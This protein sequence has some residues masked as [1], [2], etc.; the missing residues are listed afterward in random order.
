MIVTWIGYKKKFLKACV[1][2]MFFSASVWL[3]Y[4]IYRYF[5][6]PEKIGPISIH[7]GAVD[8]K[9]RYIEQNEWFKGEAI[10]EKA[11]P[12]PPAS[13]LIFRLLIG[14]FSQSSAVLVWGLT[15]L[16]A[17]GWLVF[18]TIKEAQPKARLETIFVAMI[19]LSMYASGACIGN[20]QLILHIVPSLITALLLLDRETQ[21]WQT[22]LAGIVLM[23]FSLIKPTVAAPFFWIVLFRKKG[24]L[25][26]FLVVL[27][28]GGLTQIAA[29]FQPETSFELMRQWALRGIQSSSYDAT[30]WSHNNLHS[31]STALGIEKWN[32]MLSIIMMAALGAWVYIHRSMD[33][34]ALIGVCAVVSRFWTYHGW[35]DDLLIL[36]PM[37]TLFRMT[38][39]ESASDTQRLSAG[40]F[41]AAAWLSTLAPGGTY[42]LPHPWRMIYT[43]AQSITWTAILFFLIW[44]TRTKS[45]VSMDKRDALNI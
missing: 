35:Y 42:L 28:Y 32:P 45:A 9:L 34:W 40:I 13:Y 20:G 39:S 1:M 21:Q 44:C 4:E 30:Q 14:W 22:T 27:C 25:A 16:L 7:P 15:M 31:W 19:P 23:V 43:T 26:A 38:Q 12:Y 41:L 37:I 3:S 36:M 24:L 5:I 2:L 11:A 6:Q 33:L 8:I 29:Q 17:L 18:L 10:Y